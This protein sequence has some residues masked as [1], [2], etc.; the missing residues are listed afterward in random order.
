MIRRIRLVTKDYEGVAFIYY[1]KGARFMHAQRVSELYDASIPSSSAA[2]S[3]VFDIG[4]KIAVYKVGSKPRTY[5]FYVDVSGNQPAAER[6]E[7]IT[8]TGSSITVYNENDVLICW[9][10]VVATQTSSPSSSTTAPGEMT[11]EPIDGPGEMTTE[12]IDGPGEMTSEPIDG[13]GEML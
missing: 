6:V 9:N 7:E 1:V 11:S 8:A 3:T 13:P 4:I 5:D 12:P 10:D 2:L